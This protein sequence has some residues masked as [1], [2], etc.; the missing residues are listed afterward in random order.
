MLDYR[1]GNY[2]TTHLALGLQQF[3]QVFQRA[4]LSI[5]LC[6]FPSTYLSIN[7]VAT[8]MGATKYDCD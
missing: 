1:N 4:Y 7:A 8:F 2:Q 6:I 3:G 5:C